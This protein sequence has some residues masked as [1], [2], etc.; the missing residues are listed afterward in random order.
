MSDLLPFII[1]GIA[2][3]AIYGLAGTGLVLTFKTS[4]I[5]NLGHG[6]VAAA[7]A[8]IFYFLH[9]EQEMNWVPAFLISVL[10]LGA[11]LGV[12]MEYLGRHLAHQ[13]TAMKVVGTVG[14]VLIVQGLAT[15]KYG[16]NSLRL[17]HYLPSATETFEFGGVFIAYHQV[18]VFSVAT[19][20]V[21]LLFVLFRFTRTGVAMRA[22]VDDPDLLRMHGTSAYLVRR[23]AW[24][25]GSVFAAMSG[26]LLAPQVGIEAV[27]LTF[28]VIQAFGAAAL[29][30]F[31]SIPLTF[32]G[33]IVI[34]ILS[35]LAT[36]LVISEEW[37]SGLPAGLPFLVLI[38][39]LIALPKRKLAA[40][41]TEA[42]APLQ[43]TAPVQVRL[44]CGAVILA[45]LIALPSLVGGK[46]PFY[47]VGLT[48]AIM[49]L[50]LGLMVRT[51]G[52]VSLS[53]AAFGAVGAVAFAQFANDLHMPWLLAVLLGAFIVVPVA[54]LLALPA[55]RL[56]GLYLALTTLGF[57]M[58]IE[59]M[60][61]SRGFM[62]TSL[63]DGRRMPRPGNASN[64]TYYY[65]VLAFL[66]AATAIILLIQASRLGRLLR[67]LAD[68]PLAVTTM[69]LDVR[70]TRLLVICVSGYLAGIA[71]ILY[72]SSIN[73]AVL[74][75]AK[76]T[77]FHSI[78]LLAILALAPFREPW[79]AVFGI[80]S[81]VI[82]A[83]WSTET[84]TSWMNVVFGL[85]AIMVAVQGGTPPMPEKLQ[86][87]FERFR[88][89]PRRGV[90]H[91][92]GDATAD[93]VPVPT[94]DRTGL[95]VRDMTVRFGGLVAVDN[96]SLKAETGRITGLIGPNG[97]GKTTTFNACSG[98]GRPSA[99]TV[100]LH[101]RDV[102]SYGSARRARL[103]LGRTFQTMQLGDSLSVLEN[104]RLGREASQAGAS[105][106]G[107]I[108][109]SGRDR[110]VSE[111]AALDA[112]EICGIADLADLQAG[113]L[114]TGQRRLVELARCLAGPFDLL[115]LDEPSSGLDPI[116]TQRFAEVLRNVVA[117][118][119]CGILI[120][121]H[122]M[123]LVM[124]ICDHI[125]VLDF[126]R[127]LFEG[128]AAEVATS[129]E[130][131]AAYLGSENG[132][133]ELSKA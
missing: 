65:V 31:S 87:W 106:I 13:R 19:I 110:R 119:G 72:G 9:I 24:I 74:G 111:R 94:G 49:L 112:M 63:G 20:A 130:V 2:T 98:L 7:A 78:V 45:V 128:T 11:V 44:L 60:F 86:A 133:G 84:S 71:G 85:F 34:G 8:Y 77:A 69:G 123:S 57:G 33:G 117:A 115:L 104:V 61:Y 83:Y 81:A 80:I 121:E 103:G 92:V 52:I 14:L 101:G 96:V 25:I 124:D 91:A 30:A 36:R 108:L 35:S 28:L 109:A 21:G 79:Y 97:A 102:T 53:H 10:V 90:R 122:D 47:T 95:E 39:V 127:T 38:A 131:R 5:F 27:A 42:R 99:G 48:Q 29:G 132:L 66:V 32:V 41:G 118:R 126:G 1:G 70:I 50:S 46:L 12:V 23:L 56:S 105:F 51:A 26:V 114:S 3:G 129:P 93:A 59:R 89:A 43:W 107:Q 4:G 22:V 64:E 62:F 100:T 54:A 82:P 67:G 73:F 40:G 37:L 55:I 120:V 6:A 16:F 58:L 18:Y 17:P 76:F 88:R 125:Y 75:D 116:E 15:V 68:S 113:S